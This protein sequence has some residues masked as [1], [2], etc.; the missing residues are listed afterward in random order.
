[1]TGGGVIVRV[2]T[3]SYAT[4]LR[5]QQRAAGADKRKGER[6]RDRLTLAAVQAL[7]ARGY[8]RL[9]VRDICERAQTSPAT[10]YQYFRNTE[11]ITIEVLTGF[12]QSTF[13]TGRTAAPPRPLFEALYAANLAWVSSARA[14][15]GLMRCLLQ[16][17]DQVP[18]F[19]AL[20]E[21]LSHE[22]FLHVT[23]NLRRRFPASGTDEATLLL[24]VHALGAM[25]DEMVR[26]LFVARV[27]QLRPL[28]AAT[29]PTDEAIAE[30]LSTLW[31]R[32]LLGTNPPRVRHRAS[33][34]L[35]RFTGAA[36]RRP[37]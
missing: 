31:Y 21:R 2:M 8:L 19:M 25:M 15:A 23:Q 4:I 18:E 36:T 26:K 29:A 12:L 35:L 20:H 7:E 11:H 33:R 10:F 3:L 9:R 32:A 28:I 5:R 1:M 13:H 27:K 14:N 22:W 16:L 30:F 34:G 6:T 37:A 17:G 24:A